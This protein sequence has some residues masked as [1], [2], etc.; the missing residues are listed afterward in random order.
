VDAPRLCAK[1]VSKV[2]KSD[3]EEGVKD[4]VNE[5]ENKNQQIVIAADTL[6]EQFTRV[7]TK[8]VKRKPV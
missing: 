6:V 4:L 2:P 7:V 3:A 5:K 8:K 1:I